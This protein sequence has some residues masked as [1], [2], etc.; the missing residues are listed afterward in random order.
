MNIRKALQITRVAL[1]AFAVTN[2]KDVY[3]FQDVQE[4]AAESIFYLK[5][6]HSS[7]MYG[8]SMIPL[9][10]VCCVCRI[11]ESLCRVD[12]TFEA[13][14]PTIIP[15]DRSDTKATEAGK[16]LQLCMSIVYGLA[17]NCVFMYAQP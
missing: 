17:F 4:D 7:H 5:S 10:C 16:T 15:Y 8:V 2:R 3:V 11:D 9:W 12:D 13:E 1:D 14:E 6:V